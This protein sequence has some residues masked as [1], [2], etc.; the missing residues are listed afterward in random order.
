MSHKYLLWIVTSHTKLHK[1]LKLI[2]YCKTFLETFLCI[3]H[4]GAL[5]GVE[6]DRPRCIFSALYEV[7]KQEKLY[8]F[9]LC[10]T[11]SIFWPGS[12]ACSSCWISM[13]L[14]SACEL[15]FW[16]S[17]PVDLQLRLR[18][19]HSRVPISMCFPELHDLI[20][21][22]Y[23]YWEAQSARLLEWQHRYNS[24]LLTPVIGEIKSNV[25]VSRLS[26]TGFAHADRHWIFTL[27]WTFWE[28]CG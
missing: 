8:Y 12:V 3:S 13:E 23:T 25:L 26:P 7:S 16:C 24:C 11:N 20:I 18:Q 1:L 6:N 2:L 10:V 21:S 15:L 22:S 28:A 9:S 14:W 17:R 5:F 4:E 27:H 19:A